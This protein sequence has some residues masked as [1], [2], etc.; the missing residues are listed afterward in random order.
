MQVALNA[1]LDEEESRPVRVVRSVP[2][3]TIQAFC[4]T[5]EVAGTI[6]TASKDRRMSRAH[7]K[8]HTGGIGAAVEFYQSA[9]TPNLIV[10]ETRLDAVRIMAELERLADV[11]DTGTK[12]LMIGASNDVSLYRDLMRQGISEYLVT[13]I[14]VMG[15]IGTI[16]DIYSEESEEKL[17]QSYAFVG[18]KGGVGSSTI[19]HNIAWTMARSFGSDVILADFDLPFGTASLDFN[20]DPTQ[21]IAEAIF[22][23]DR[24]DEVLLDRLLAKC[25][26]HLN[27][28]AAPAQLDNDYDLSADSFDHVLE[29]MQSNVPTVVVDMP[30][31]WTPWSKRM[32]L[33]VDEVVITAS[34]DLANLRNAKNM[35]DQLRQA[36]PNDV[37][38]RLILN[39]VGVPKRPEISAD[40][41]VSALQVEP[42]ATFA[43]DP[44]LFGTAANNGQ[45]IGEASPKAGAAE[46]FV[47]VA[48]LVTGRKET[49]QAKKKLDL[50]PLLA[51]MTQ[52]TAAKQKK[53]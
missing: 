48:Q 6:E 35:I 39:Q 8:V 29:V 10:V 32:L 47:D 27:L 46:Q 2:R 12:L 11:C 1:S 53:K 52:K 9:P 4:D 14:D 18:A 44:L 34:P 19:A 17:G 41:F 50:K 5:P 28:L 40:D 15:I 3:I 22:A 21:G 16:S 13:P 37:P 31:A 38:P 45:M 42:M 26:E 30:H 49:R 33:A 20:Q 25:G 51:M 43:Y 7:V 23:P 24:L 36:R